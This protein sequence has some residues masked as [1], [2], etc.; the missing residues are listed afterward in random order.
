M[1]KYQKYIVSREYKSIYYFLKDNNFS[2]NFITNLRKEMGNLKINGEAVTIRSPLK[3]GD[4]IEIKSNPIKKTTIMHCIIPLDIVFED[5]Y[6]LL[7]NKPSGLSSMPSR[8]H[9]SSNL[10][11]AICYY[12]EKKDKNFTLRIINRLDKDTAGLV[13]VAKDS[14][15]QKDIKDIDKTYYAICQGCIDKEL[16]ID[17]RIKTITKNGLNQNKRVVSEDG[18][19][20]TTYVYPVKTNGKLSL[21]KLKLV[22][23]RT[24]QIRV[25]LASIGYPLLNDSLYGDEKCSPNTHTMLICKEMSF[26]HPYKKEVLH[27]AVDFP[28][29]FKTIIDKI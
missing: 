27:F 1:D 13:L 5:D 16:V 17:K 12:M 29:D 25:H 2:E 24:H 19:D 10:A 11:G 20:A 28:N 26:Y 8:S 6:Y 15:A 18:K 22:H 21:I 3:I 7:I 23:G 9:Y 4:T 14:I